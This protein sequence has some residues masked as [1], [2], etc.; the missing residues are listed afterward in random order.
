MDGE[1][2][3][4]TNYIATEGSTIITLKADY[5]KTLS[6]GSHSFEIV[7]EDGMASTNFNVVKKT[8]DND[9]N[10][11][12]N[13]NNDDDNDNNNNGNDNNNNSSDNNNGNDNNN[14]SGNHNGNGSDNK[15]NNSSTNAGDNKNNNAN[16][17]TN[18]AGLPGNKKNDLSD[19]KGN[20]QSTTPAKTGDST[21]LTLWITLLMASIAGIT[22]IFTRRKKKDCK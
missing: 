1:L 21:N 17:N 19:T 5:L 15:H 6:V 2:I 11:G 16:S 9:H 18:Q 7:W 8:S 3:D 4:S 13:D 10:N 14:S 20:H 22:G 12:N